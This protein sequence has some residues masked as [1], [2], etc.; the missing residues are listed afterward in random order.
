MESVACRRHIGYARMH[1][2]CLKK[3]V[4]TQGNYWESIATYPTLMKCVTL[5][6]SFVWTF[7]SDIRE[8]DRAFYRVSHWSFLRY[9]FH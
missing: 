5:D 4:G 3:V 7:I 8:T 2:F 9:M 6:G 1:E